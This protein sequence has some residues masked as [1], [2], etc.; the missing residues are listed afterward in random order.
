MFTEAKRSDRKHALAQTLSKP[1]TGATRRPCIG[2]SASFS[3]S[4]WQ[5]N[6]SQLN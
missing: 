6:L 5:V 2:P 3:S 4:G 1:M